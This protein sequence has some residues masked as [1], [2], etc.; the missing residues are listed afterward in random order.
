MET[1]CSG[2]RAVPSGME[3][4]LPSGL[5]LPAHCVVPLP[6]SPPSV[7]RRR[8]SLKNHPLINHFY[9]HSHLRV[10]FRE[11]HLRQIRE[12]NERPSLQRRWTGVLF[13]TPPPSSPRPPQGKLCFPRGNKKLSTSA[14]G[15][16]IDCAEQSRRKAVPV[17]TARQVL[18]THGISHKSCGNL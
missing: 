2:T 1:L 11:H 8:H 4:D 17:A 3:P 12:Q 7:S 14:N 16:F 9:L 15:A 6:H 5:V 13:H 18:Q 10:C